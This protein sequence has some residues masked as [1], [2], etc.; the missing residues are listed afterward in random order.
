MRCSHA[1][2]P[3]AGRACSHLLV[4]DHDMIQ[5]F[6]GRGSEHAWCCR[7][8]TTAND[9]G[10][11]LDVCAACMAIVERQG[12]EGIEGEPE[13]LVLPSTIRA[14]H[15][16]IDLAC[17]PLV[18][19]QPI[20]GEDRERWIGLAADGTVHELDIATRSV[21]ELGR[22]GHVDPT[23]PLVLF[24]S[25]GARFIAVANQRGTLGVVIERA[26]WRTT[27]EITRDGYQVEH[28]SFPLAFV[29]QAGRTL[30]VY[31]PSWN[32]LE[33]AEA[34]TGELLSARG[35]ITYERGAPTPSHYLDYFHC[36]LAVSP[37]QRMIADAGW[38]WA[39]VG[40][41]TGWSVDAWLTNPYESEDGSTW[42]RL[43]QRAYF[44]DGPMAWLDDDRLVVWGYGEDDEWMLPA[45]LIRNAH[46][47]KLER[48]FAGVPRGELWCDRWLYAATGVALSVWDVDRG[49]RIAEIP[50]DATRYHPDAKCFATIPTAGAITRVRLTGHDGAWC[51][52][53][54]AQLVARGEP[55]DLPILA[56]LL[57]AAGYADE[58]VLAHCRRPGPHGGRCWVFD[59]LSPANA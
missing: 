29:E 23:Q 50:S 9:D 33:L 47:G 48:W 54:I 44:W 36:S 42:Q 24:V 8:C 27:I 3:I 43:G 1:D 25:A 31:A 12:F 16:Q 14:V 4:G 28:C 20:T 58:E 6:T 26:T 40:L 13:T 19:L 34:A 56:D 37:G 7:D 11:V 46:T 21:R 15:E 10:A 38:C 2:A 49:A 51:T 30:V 32:R 52:G 35:P 57:E 22:A 17:P 39:P 59:R 55:D 41:V 18:D 45:A 5:V 53:K